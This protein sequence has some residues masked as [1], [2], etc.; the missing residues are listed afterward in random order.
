MGN[1]GGSAKDQDAN[2]N[3]DSKG[4]A[5]EHPHGNKVSSG[6]WTRGYL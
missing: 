6:N 3:A 4:Y 1:S 2:S 5:D